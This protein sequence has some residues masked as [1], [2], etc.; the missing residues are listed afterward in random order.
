[1]NWKDTLGIILF[2]AICFAFTNAEK[3]PK[4]KITTGLARELMF[5]HFE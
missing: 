4:V 2:V 3:E 5:I 1:M